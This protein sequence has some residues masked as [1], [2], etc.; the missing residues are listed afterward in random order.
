ME[1]VGPGP[2][3]WSACGRGHPRRGVRRGRRRRAS[4]SDAGE[5]VERRATSTLKQEDWNKRLAWPRVKVKPERAGGGEGPVKKP[6]GAGPRLRMLVWCPVLLHHLP[7]SRT[8]PPFAGNTWPI[9]GAPLARS[10]R[11]LLLQRA[12]PL[13]LPPPPSSTTS[14]SASV[15]LLLFLLLDLLTLGRGGVVRLFGNGSLPRRRLSRRPAPLFSGDGS[16]ISWTLSRGLN[17]P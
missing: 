1:R 6:A 4:R 3:S 15:C 2:E 5:V 17:E 13:H 12:S 10:R 8:Q 11:F 16:T 9:F 7:S 14:S